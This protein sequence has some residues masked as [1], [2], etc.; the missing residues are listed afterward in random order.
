[1][2]IPDDLLFYIC[3]ITDISHTKYLRLINKAMNEY[4]SLK[5]KIYKMVNFIKRHY[6]PYNLKMMHKTGLV[7]HTNKLKNK[8]HVDKNSLLENLNLIKNEQLCT[9]VTQYYYNIQLTT[10]SVILHL[11]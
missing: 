3:D 1:M 6:S 11:L 5:Y 10:H 2:E 8:I 7:I 4:V 9:Y